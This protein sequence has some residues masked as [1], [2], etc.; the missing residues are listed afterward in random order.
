MLGYLARATTSGMVTKAAASLVAARH[1]EM[2]DHKTQ[3]RVPASDLTQQGQELPAS[4]AIGKPRRSA[5]GHSQSIVPSVG[6]DFMCGCRK[7]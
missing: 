1:A 7:V 3:A 2:I 4:R 6:Q 5:A